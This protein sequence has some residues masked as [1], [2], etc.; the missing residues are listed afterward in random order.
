M[1][2]PTPHKHELDVEEFKRTRYRPLL[3][4]VLLEN[5]C[6]QDDLIDVLDGK[7]ASIGDLASLVEV[8]PK[9]VSLFEDDDKG[10][11]F[12]LLDLD[13]QS[14]RYHVENELSRIAGE[15]VAERLII[16][17]CELFGHQH[18][19][20]RKMLD[21][22]S[23]TPDTRAFDELSNNFRRF[24]PSRNP[25]R[26]DAVTVPSHEHALAI[27]MV[28]P[29]I[30]PIELAR[31]VGVDKSTLYRKNTKWNPV[32]QTLMARP[33]EHMPRGFKDSDGTIEAHE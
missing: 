21:Q 30:S 18:S 19:R 10:L 2:M 22:L 3:R 15:G 5:G 29:E 25:Q 13:I 27:L 20:N 17:L 16:K 14:I 33:K 1:S 9:V 12:M 26:K 4:R 23:R 8:T 6:D 31:R 32:R 11:I 7:P 28:K 24:A